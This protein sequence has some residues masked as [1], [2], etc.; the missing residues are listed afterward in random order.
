MD[1]RE[2]HVRVRFV[3]DGGHSID[4]T[5]PQGRLA[6]Q[7]ADLSAVDSPPRPLRASPRST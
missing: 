1:E 5:A 3:R 7:I 4:E 2:P 6:C